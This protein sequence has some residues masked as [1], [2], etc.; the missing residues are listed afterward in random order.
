MVTSSTSLGNIIKDKLKEGSSSHYG[1]FFSDVTD[2]AHKQNEDYELMMWTGLVDKNGVE[3]YEGDVVEQKTK[4][5]EDDTNTAVGMIDFKAPAFLIKLGPD[6]YTSLINYGTN[7]EVIGN[8]WE[9]P[10]TYYQF[11]MPDVEK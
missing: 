7:L 1:S 4:D 6:K 3:I 10:L 11:I 2:S 8:V 5:S 9:N